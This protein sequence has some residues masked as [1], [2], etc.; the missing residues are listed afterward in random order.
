MLLA[1]V[2]FSN[3]YLPTKTNN[4]NANVCCVDEGMCKNTWWYRKGAQIS[5]IINH[6]KQM[7][8]L[9]RLNAVL[10]ER[11]LVQRIP[12]HTWMIKALW[13]VLTALPG[14]LLTWCLCKH[15]CYT[16]RI[17]FHLLGKITG[18]LR[19]SHLKQGFSNLIH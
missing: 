16:D 15:R 6:H 4:Q 5:S 8:V 14:T 3:I 19:S 2:L 18:Y 17:P 12:P 1:T 10:P 9:L 7:L 11:H 13:E